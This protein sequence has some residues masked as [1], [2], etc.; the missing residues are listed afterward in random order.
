ML[1]F[2]YIN[3]IIREVVYMRSIHYWKKT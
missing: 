3:D 2:S 1:C